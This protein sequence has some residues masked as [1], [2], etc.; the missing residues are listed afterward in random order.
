M[1]YIDATYLIFSDKPFDIEKKAE[2]IA[3]NSIVGNFENYPQELK[4]KLEKYK[5][6]IVDVFD[7]K[8]SDSKKYKAVIKIGYPVVL[9]NHDIPSILTIIFGKLSLEKNIKLIDLDFHPAFLDHFNGPRYGIN[10]IRDMLNVHHEPLLM[11]TFQ[12]CFGLDT[13]EFAD[14]FFKQAVGGVDFV[15]DDEIFFDDTFAPFEKRIEAC[16]KRAEESEKITGRKTLYVPNLTGHV[17][18][19]IEKAKRGID[20]GGKA[21]L[22]NVLPYGFDVL[23]RLSEEVDAVF[24]AYPSFSGAI[25]QS[26]NVGIEASVLLG[27]LMRIAGADMVLFPS[28]YGDLSL[29]HHKIMEITE[30]L[31]EGLGNIKP[32]FPVPSENINPSLVPKMFKDFGTNVVINAGHT[33]HEHPMGTT[34]GAKAFRDAV[35]C[36]ISGVLIEECAAASEELKTA[37]E[38]WK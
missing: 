25:Y 26:E 4:K 29:T 27:K 30:S 15:K 2:E 10:G 14:K 31:K 16:V 36:V 33:I 17:D 6:R 24:V 22:I 23:Q 32:S 20:A 34:A 19:I 3:V 8:D 18:E 7:F 9:F 28:P 35:D 1:N 11:T 13:S 5:G 21:F 37:L 38:K 12:T